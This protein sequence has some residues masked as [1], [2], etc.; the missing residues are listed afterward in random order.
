MELFAAEDRDL[1]EISDD[2]LNALK[3]VLAKYNATLALPGNNMILRNMTMD[4][5]RTWNTSLNPVTGNVE[6]YG[7][8]DILVEKLQDTGLKITGKDVT[9][10]ELQQDTLPT[11]EQE[12]IDQELEA[13][14]GVV[15]KIY[16]KSEL[17][18]SPAK[19]LTGKVK[20]L[21]STIK[22]G[23]TNKFGV[24]TYLDRET[25]YRELLEVFTGK[26][27]FNDMVTALENAAI[28]KPNIINPVLE[29]VKG[30]DA[31]QKA[32]LYNA[33]A[34]ATTEFVLIEK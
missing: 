20:E 29:F 24:D 32:M 23:Q 8:R 3:A 12:A 1:K 15:E 22:S 2:S 6:K 19:R 7:W 13:I 25:V 34:L 17:N 28:Y 27:T 31:P 21:L 5:Y 10:Y 16:G 18:T 4:I 33:F 26:Q 9:E 30:L 11:D 14:D